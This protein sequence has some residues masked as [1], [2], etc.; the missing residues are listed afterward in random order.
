MKHIK[1]ISLFFLFIFLLLINAF[2][3]EI[4]WTTSKPMQTGRSFL[5]VVVVNNKIYAIGGGTGTTSTI[6][7]SPVVE[8]YDPILNDWDYIDFLNISRHS[9][10]ACVL[11]N[12]I[13]VIGGFG[14]NNRMNAGEVYDLVSEEW[15]SIDSMQIPRDNLG[16][17][18]LNNKIYA[19]GGFGNNGRV[20]IVEVY[21]PGTDT[22]EYSSS[23]NSY[24]DAFTVAIVNNKIYVIG[25]WDGYNRHSVVEVYDPENDIWSTATSMPTARNG[26]A[27]GVINY[28]IY[29]IGGESI[30]YQYSNPLVEKGI[31]VPLL[32]CTGFEPPMANGPVKV[33]KNRVLPLKTQLLDIDNNE[34]IIT[35]LDITSLPVI[36]VLYDSCQTGEPEDVT[37]QTLPAGNGTEGNQF[38]FTV[39]NKWQYNL[40]TSNYTAIGTY[41][42]YIKSG[43]S[44]EYIIDQL[45][46]SPA[47]FVIDE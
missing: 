42:I 46:Y 43:D 16:V 9:F 28:T 13:Y 7:P 33:K 40:K 8:I 21:D 38:E 31:L 14:N 17:C 2:T 39:D 37:D 19:I 20:D 35:G 22:W 5:S 34:I 18:A 25:G 4:T 10:G 29:A 41:F 30:M 23:M 12:K 26:L 44:S 1:I 32:S 6:N 27:V 15:S 11:N 36:Q 47:Q 3:E 45:S 24:R